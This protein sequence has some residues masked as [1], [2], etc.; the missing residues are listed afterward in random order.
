MTP[1]IIKDNDYSY[2]LNNE[3]FTDSTINVPSILI[4]NIVFMWKFTSFVKI[5]SYEDNN[6]LFKFEIGN[7]DFTYDLKNEITNYIFGC[8]TEKYYEYYSPILFTF[9]FLKK[10]KL[11]PLD[12]FSGVLYNFFDNLKNNLNKKTQTSIKSDIF[13]EE[14]LFSSHKE[15][16]E[17]ISKVNSKIEKRDNSKINEIF[18]LLSAFHRYYFMLEKL[19]NKCKLNN[20]FY[21]E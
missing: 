16:D 7:I 9:E 4:G 8:N 21:L 5:L 20:K 10:I 17:C 11:L 2:N 18:I 13:E 14:F 6:H 12:I 3:E 19:E 1:A 15:I